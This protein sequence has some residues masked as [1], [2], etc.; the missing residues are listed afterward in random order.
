MM[1]D[2]VEFQDGDFEFADAPMSRDFIIQAF[3]KYGLRYI[4]YF[5]GDLF[6]AEM[7]DGE[8]FI[9]FYG[10]TYYVDEVE[11]IM[12]FMTRERIGVIRY[13]AG[14]LLKKPASKLS[15]AGDV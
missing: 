1:Q 15:D 9:P 13:E 10:G 14:T 5:G 3:E 12:D 6:Y 8:P 2:L 7:T 4:A 11:L